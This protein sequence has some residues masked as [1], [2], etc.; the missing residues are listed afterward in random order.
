M[1]ERFG[2]VDQN[3]VQE[4]VPVMDGLS[5]AINCIRPNEQHPY[6]VLFTNGMSELPMKVPEEQADWQLA[7]L[8]MHLPLDWRLPTDANVDPKWLWPVQWLRKMAYFPHL[9]DTWL[10]LPA[11][12][13]SSDDPPVPLGP[14]VD[15]TCLLLVPDFA[16]LDPP[17]KRSD[18]SAV[19]FFTVVPLYTE[20]R[21]YE[22]QHGMEEFF[23]QFVDNEVPM[24]VNLARPNFGL[25]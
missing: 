11:T 2:P 12:I 24:V 20:E 22:L 5:V 3:A 4:L 17:L 7:E 21:D 23:E 6:L 16:N 13:V 9:N 1:E 18:G 10:G 8:V 15:Q 25:T 19:H 14:N